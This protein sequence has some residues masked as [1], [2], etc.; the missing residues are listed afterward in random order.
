[1]QEEHDPV[2]NAVEAV[3]QTSHAQAVVEQIAEE[4]KETANEVDQAVENVEHI[5]QATLQVTAEAL[6]EMEARLSA[7]FQTGIEAIHG[8]ISEIEGRLPAIPVPEKEPDVEKEIDETLEE[9][10]KEIEE[11]PVKLKRFRRL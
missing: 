6:S 4:I 8:R 3:A 1:M 7:S 11:T 9:P 5:A 2:E 10:E